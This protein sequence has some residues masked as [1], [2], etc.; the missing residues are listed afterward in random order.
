MRGKK[1]HISAR[2]VR[3]ATTAIMLIF[4]IFF[5]SSTAARRPRTFF[6]PLRGLILEN[7]G[8][9]ASVEKMN[10]TWRMLARSDT[11]TTVNNN[12][13]NMIKT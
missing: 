10:P 4:I 11:T 2:I 9:I 1:P 8:A 12:G 3:N 5:S 13:S 6:K 7:F